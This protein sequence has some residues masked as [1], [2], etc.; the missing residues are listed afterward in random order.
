MMS[1]TTMLVPVQVDALVVGKE[2]TAPPGFP[3]TTQNSQQGQNNE[4]LKVERGV[5]I[6]WAL[7]DCLTR[8]RFVDA[9]GNPGNK[10]LLLPGVPDLWLVVRFNPVDSTD[11]LS[12]E[13][14]AVAWI[15]ESRSR[16]KYDFPGWHPDANYGK[17]QIFTAFGEFSPAKLPR[18]SSG[19]AD[20]P[21][22][23]NHNICEAAYYPDCQTKF[24][25]Y[26]D[27]SGL[28][29]NPVDPKSTAQLTY[30]VIGWHS[31]AL[32]DPIVGA[33][34]WK[35]LIEEWDLDLP[36]MWRFP[37]VTGW[38]HPFAPWSPPPQGMA[39]HGCVLDVRLSGKPKSPD[40]SSPKPPELL[41]VPS[42]HRAIAEIALLGKSASEEGKLGLEAVILSADAEVLSG[43]TDDLAH[44]PQLASL[45]NTLHAKSFQGRAGQGN[46]YAQIDLTEP[47]SK[48]ALAGEGS[49]A[50]VAAEA[51]LQRIA[52][53]KNLSLAEQ[54]TLDDYI[55]EVFTASISDAVKA[56]KSIDPRNQKF[57]RV[58]ERRQGADRL[59]M[60]GVPRGPHGAAYWIDLSDH[61]AM[62]AFLLASYGAEMKLPTENRVFERPGQSWFRPYSPHLILQNIGRAYR[63]GFDGR[64]EVDG[65]VRC[66][67]AL[68]VLN[69]LELDTTFAPSGTESDVALY[70][71]DA[72]L[73]PSLNLLG[74][75]T[76]TVG[77]PIFV[78]DL[79]GETL[80]LDSDS[81]DRLASVWAAQTREALPE[82][83]IDQV[84]EKATSL[85][86]QRLVNAAQLLRDPQNP[87]DDETQSDLAFVKPYLPSPIAFIPWQQP[88]A[89]LFANITYSYQGMKT[90]PLGPVD[91][92]LLDP[93]T[94]DGPLDTNKEQVL[95]SVV[96]SQVLESAMVTKKVLDFDGQL[97]YANA[98]SNSVP[99]DALLKMDVLSCGLVGFDDWL[100][101]K[102]AS[103]RAG[104]IT[105]KK[106][107]VVDAF[108]RWMDIS[109]DE[110]SSPSWQVVDPFGNSTAISLT[111]DTAHWRTSLNARLPQWAR[112][113]A[114]LLSG[115]PEP[116]ASS[117][118]VDLKYA[119]ADLATTP[120]CGYF[121][122]NLLEHT[123]QIYD[124]DGAPLGQLASDPPVWVSHEPRVAEVGI[125]RV[126]VLP[127]DT[128]PV[129]MVHF[130]VNGTK[131]DPP[132]ITNPIL[133]SFVTSLC[134]PQSEIQPIIHDDR[135]VFARNYID[136]DFWLAPVGQIKIG[137]SNT[138]TGDGTTNIFSFASTVPFNPTVSVDGIVKNHLP[139]YTISQE[140]I[141]FS[142]APVAGSKI[143]ISD[144]I[145]YTG[146]GYTNTYD[147]GAL[148]LDYTVSV[149]DKVLREEA[150]YVVLRK[151]WLRESALTGLLRIAD[152]VR[153][154]VNPADVSGKHVVRLVGP[155]LALVH[156]RLRLERAAQISAKPDESALI[157]NTDRDRLSVFAKVGCILQP[158]DG[159]IGCFIQSASNGKSYFRAV[160]KAAVE[161]ALFNGLADV[162][163]G[164][165]T[166][167]VVN[168]FLHDP[169]GG[170]TT[171]PV[172]TGPGQGGQTLDQWDQWLEM[173]VLL[174]VRG[175][176]Y[177][178]S[179]VLPRE[180]IA[181]SREQLAGALEKLSPT[182]RTGPV[183]AFPDGKQTNPFLP[184]PLVPGYQCQWLA[185]NSPA[186]EALPRLPPDGV[187]T[188]DRCSMTQGWFTLSPTQPKPAAKT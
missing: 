142:S 168:A 48:P 105:I 77:F 86:L 171:F 169:D 14:K 50:A 124:S 3:S 127:A 12:A 83:R 65:R 99:A 173:N 43:R 145:T 24:G 27:L 113:R 183:L 7:P 94:P 41:V 70:G 10:H 104:L 69:Y 120:V 152:T 54:K 166:A 31:S 119:E 49:A 133:L 4:G 148:G 67:Y 179:G 51:V 20:V 53:G 71:K 160:D 40:S 172:L 23:L 186:P 34:D 73:E 182:F 130:R 72:G 128:T 95:L 156:A 141:V 164:I 102:N 85:R 29:A 111:D 37:T 57:V 165:T 176:I 2:F 158:D 84:V 100:H 175:G 131:A 64:F 122:P 129:P 63:Y 98:P 28:G 59:M 118:H 38:P 185:E 123:L 80:L 188:T 61:D 19:W 106:V 159:V 177:L 16:R 87:L 8:G 42:L 134:Q 46:F 181:P 66:R 121:V 170:D 137:R 155:P 163:R 26:D 157:P 47:K 153:P 103:L 136:S 139:D 36:P 132:H 35:V 44:N 52:D 109:L 74:A 154:T 30:A 62:K 93:M 116:S 33:F 15:I 68:A 110:G 1:T 125:D 126:A 45:F 144:S 180:K 138:Y 178:T 151:I 174:D 184:K 143:E 32:N 76:N 60:P 81:A 146:N 22:N 75:T 101:T 107:Q 56:I 17:D 150:D 88:W 140:N 79:L 97:I 25:L 82:A 114:Q 13:R 117:A 5:H 147:T 161:N 149:E 6:H 112:L 39:C 91:W 108:G 135:I 11:G 78:S 21:T 89:P 187:I 58:V 167:A 90:E 55:G 96:G 9:E 162:S 115:D 18:Y 92:E